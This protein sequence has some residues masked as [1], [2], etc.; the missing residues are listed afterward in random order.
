MTTILAAIV[1]GLLAMSSQLVMRLL[2]EWGDVRV[3]IDAWEV[4]YPQG[5]N[6]G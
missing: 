5:V 2:R 4:T 1:G 3:R 6:T